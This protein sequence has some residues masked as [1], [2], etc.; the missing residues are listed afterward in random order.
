MGDQ[1]VYI[2][3]NSQGTTQPC[4]SIVIP[5]CNQGQFIEQ[6]ITSVLGQN[7]P[8]I[9]LII[10][11]GGSTDATADIVRKYQERISYW[12]S[13]PDHGQAEAIN[14]GF[15]QARGDILGWLNTDDMYLPCTFS[16]VA[17]ILKPV[18]ESGLVYGGCLHVYEGTTHTYGFLPPDFDA[19]QLTYT[20]YLIQPSTFWTRALWEQVGNLNESYHYVLDWEWFIRAARFCRFIPIKDYL[21]IYR[22][23]PTHKSGQGN[24]QRQEEIMHIIE[25]YADRTWQD[26]YRAVYQHLV[27]LRRNF[28]RLWRI[29]LYWLRS[30]FYPR[31]YWK[32]GKQRIEDV[33][34]SMLV[35]PDISTE[36]GLNKLTP[37][38]V[39]QKL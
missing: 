17:A 18:S 19:E 21:S 35:V 33:I 5:S 20:D 38:Q 9:E 2:F 25:T 3:M 1:G 37:P 27:P 12:I 28:H 14:K 34:L 13:E 11:D 24:E 8:H 32:Y 22:M 15:T 36:P 6:A 31:L 26:A 30:L 10:V 39:R 4:I 16:K 7:Y 23:H 29:K